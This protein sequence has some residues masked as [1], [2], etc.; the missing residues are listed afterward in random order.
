MKVFLNNKMRSDWI[1]LKFSS[2]YVFTSQ[3]KYQKTKHTPVGLGQASQ[4][5]ITTDHCDVF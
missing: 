1:D 4:Q 2:L 3:K 5:V